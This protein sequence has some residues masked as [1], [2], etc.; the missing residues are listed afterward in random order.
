MTPRLDT[1]LMTRTGVRLRPDVARSV[2]RLFV[3]GQEEVGGGESRAGD[4]VSRV[5]ALDEADVERSLADVMQRFDGRHREFTAILEHHA[6]RVAH[7]VGHHKA[8][9]TARRLLLGATF[10]HE[11]SIE[12]AALCNPSIVLDPDQRGAPAGG[13]RFIMSVRG[14]GEGH[15]SSIGFRTGQVDAEGVVTVDAPGAFPVLG[16][17]DAGPIHRAVVH[18]KLSLISDDTESAAF[19]LEQLSAEFSTAV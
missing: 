10:T 2:A 11:Y 8:L 19:L 4:V 14:I 3:A 7:R 13:A 5:L 9:S 15:R 18:G 17:I 16:A 1:G 6:A 12:A